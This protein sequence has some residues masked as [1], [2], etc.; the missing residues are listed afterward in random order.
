MNIIKIS[1]LAL[2]GILLALTQKNGKSEYTT[3]IALGTTV[4]IFF[5]V[6]GKIG[7]IVDAVNTM[8][9]YV[10]INETYIKALIK[11]VG[12]T[13]I[14]EFTASICKDSGYGAVAG[15]V[16]MFG[17]LSILALSMPVLLSL[18]ETINKCVGF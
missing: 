1:V 7:I 13:Y 2:A 11:I 9:S 15:Q 8:Q 10:K 17:K 12:I 16:E 3:Y 14:S 18:M 6:V 5:Y 4:I